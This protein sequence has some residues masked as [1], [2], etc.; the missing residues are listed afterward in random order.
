M[1]KTLSLISILALGASV[2]LTGCSDDETDGDGMGGE[3][4]GDGD[5]GMGGMGGSP[6]LGGGGMG[7]S[8]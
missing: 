1:K 2:A 4:G 3:N 7:G 5:G 6:A 8:L